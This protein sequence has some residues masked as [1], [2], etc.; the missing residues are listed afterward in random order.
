MVP[1]IKGLDE[2]SLNDIYNATEMTLE[3]QQLE[4]TKELKKFMQNKG[5]LM[6][7]DQGDQGDLMQNKGEL[8]P[9][10]NFLLNPVTQIL[11]EN[12]ENLYAHPLIKSYVHMRMKKDMVYVWLYICLIINVGLMV[13][14]TG[15]AFS[16]SV[17][18]H[19]H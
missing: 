6:Q 11:K 18:P 2:L 3:F 7:G 13:C 17:W 9:I 19:L 1:V 10:D 16:E 4:K 8:R 15:F 14:L 5:D 12:A